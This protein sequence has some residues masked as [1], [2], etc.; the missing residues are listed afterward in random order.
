L[1]G[2]RTGILVARAEEFDANG[3]KMPYKVAD[4]GV[5]L[6]FLGTKTL[7]NIVFENDFKCL[8]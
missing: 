8:P 6:G 2:N 3:T 4:V 5:K 7:D 1:H